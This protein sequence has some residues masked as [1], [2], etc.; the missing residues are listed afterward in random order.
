MKKISAFFFLC[1]LALTAAAQTANSNRAAA[2][3]WWGYVTNNTEK[4]GLGVS[5]ADTYHC[6]IFI[7]GNHDVASGKTIKSVRFGLTAPSATNAKVWLA[8]SLPTTVDANNTLQFVEVSDK[9]LGKEDINI[10]LPTSYAIPAEGVY[11][12]YSF[13]ITAASQTDDKYPILVTGSDAPNALILKTDQA[14]KKWSDM[15]GQGYGSL[16][17]QVLLEGEFADNTATA[18]NFG[19]VYAVLGQTGTAKLPV[20]NEGATPINSIDYTI[21]TDGVTSEEVHADVATPIVFNTTGTVEICVPADAAVG[22]KAKTLNITKV[23]GNANTKADVA[24]K[25]NLITV[26]EWVDRNVVVEEYTGT[27]CGWCPRGLIG[28]E[29]LR[30]KYGDRFVGIG[31]HQYNSSDA[32]YIASNAYAKL[33]F[34][35][36]PSCQIDR[37]SEVDPYYGSNK[38]I[39]DDFSEEMAIPAFAKVSVSGTVDEALTQVSAKAEVEALLDD[40]KYTL[41][42]V[43]I[44]DGLKGTG[45]AWN[46]ANYYNTQFTASQL[47][48]DLAIFGNGGKYGKS[49]ITGWEFNDVAL[50][51]S[52]VN[53]VNKAPALGTMLGG[54]KKEVEYTLALPQKT[55]LKNALKKDQLYIIALVVDRDKTIANAAKAKIQ[56]A[57]PTGIEIVDTDSEIEGFYT[58]DGKRLS[59]PVKGMNVVKMTNGATKKIVIR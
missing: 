51:S 24:T 14:V 44:G 9:K 48:A 4:T 37:K 29:K 30:A 34:G 15:N 58:I 36:A 43:V 23:N 22:T 47:P 18:A 13:T 59:A 49:T 54:E 56:V 17:L 45:S 16:F 20:T 1:L 8:S 25:F 21:T 50:C 12:G 3:N 19:P 11:V 46:Q 32:M 26:P 31:L 27:G 28:M 52:Y 39:L 41:E 53:S 57:D 40:S 38:D 33:T 2:E 42:F 55:T 5:A 35:G 10:E 7:P 6:A